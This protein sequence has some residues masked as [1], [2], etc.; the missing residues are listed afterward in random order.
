MPFLTP[1]PAFRRHPPLDPH[2]LRNIS[3]KLLPRTLTTP[4]SDHQHHP[5][6]S[7]GCGLVITGME[8]V[9]Y[10]GSCLQRS[11]LGF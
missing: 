1:V 11:K 4:Q 9:G 2:L 3:S 5:F 7:V 8:H 6:A 10:L